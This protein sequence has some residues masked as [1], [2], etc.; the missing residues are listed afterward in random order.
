MDSTEIE[1][2]KINSVTTRTIWGALMQTCQFAHFKIPGIQYISMNERLE[3][4]KDLKPPATQWPFFQYWVIGNKGHI[5]RI[6]ATDNETYIDEAK[7]DGDHAAPFN[8]IPFVMRP[9]GSD[10]TAAERANYIL[11]KK[12]THNDVAYWCYYG[13]RIPGITDI[14]PTVYITTT[15]DGVSN[16]VE[17]ETSTANIYPQQKVIPPDTAITTSSDTLTVSAPV[18]I[19]FS[20]NDAQE[21][22]NVAKIL[23]NGNE[24]RAVI[25]EIGLCTGLDS[26]YQTT[27][28][29]GAPI[30]FNDALAVWIAAFISTYQ[31]LVF[32]NKGFKVE[33]ELGATEPVTTGTE[34]PD[35][36]AVDALNQA[37]VSRLATAG[38]NATV[39]VKN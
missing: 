17:Y 10:L 7:H 6:D 5:N 28:D 31:S 14:T 4:L 23:Y 33:L 39:S 20:P 9:E 15:K 11:R 27:S 21:L 32:N 19:D 16:T 1:A 8:P 29:G 12:E 35:D 13:K 37:R 2:T 25:S 18:T 3:I 26:S 22:I 24:K 34:V 38:I 30:M 36:Q